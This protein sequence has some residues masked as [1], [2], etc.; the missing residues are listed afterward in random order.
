MSPGGS[1]RVETGLRNSTVL[2]PLG[3]ADHVFVN[4]T[5]WDDS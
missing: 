2:E 5:R 4:H 1:L 3:Q